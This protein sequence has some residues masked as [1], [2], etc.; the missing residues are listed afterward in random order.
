MDLV[1]TRRRGEELDRALLDAAWAELSEHGYPA[2]TIDAVASR[3]G[4]SRPVLYRR[5]PTK[6]DLVLAAMK[7]AGLFE[8]RPLADTGSL[9]GD[10]LQALHDFNETRSGFIA[11]I[12][13]YLANIASDTGLSPADLRLRMLDGRRRGPRI[14]LERAVARGEIPAADWP[15]GIVSLPFDLFRQDVLMTLAH[16]P[17]KRILEIVDEIFLPL[18]TRAPGP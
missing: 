2:F 7:H 1:R 6:T 5:W 4:T 9:R 3:A 10:V 18:V 8:R 16:V 15:P 12:S 17:E 14:F 13:V 11:T